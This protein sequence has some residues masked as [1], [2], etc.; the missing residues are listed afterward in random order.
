MSCWK[1]PWIFLHPWGLYALF[2]VYFCFV[3]CVFVFS[4]NM[5][6][7]YYLVMYLY[8]GKSVIRTS[9]FQSYHIF[10]RR[11][12][13]STFF[14]IIYCKNTT[15]ISNSDTCVLKNFILRRNLSVPIKEIPIEIHWKFEVW[16]ANIKVT[17]SDHNFFVREF[18][19]SSN[20]FSKMPS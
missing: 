2:P 1:S 15:D 5:S 4:V 16:A 11:V 7:C 10:W 17:H 18:K 13:V 3:V 14:T 19:R 9:I 20:Y 6:F 8:S 12:T